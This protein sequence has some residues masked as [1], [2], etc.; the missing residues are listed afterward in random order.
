MSL[1]FTQDW[2]VVRGKEDAYAGFVT[3]TFIPECNKLGL[4]S[5]GGFYVQVGVGPQVISIKSAKSLSSLYEAMGSASFRELKAKLREYVSNYSSK[6]LEPAEIT[7]GKEYEIQKGV[8]KYN[9]YY[10][11]RPGNREAYERYVKETYLPALEEIDYVEVTERWN[12]LI[13]GFSEAIV[14]L[15]FQHP[16][17]IGRLLDNPQFREVTYTMSRDYVRN[18]K[19]RI[20]R[21]TERFDEPRWFRL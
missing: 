18:Y 1:L 6:I 13:G 2:D 17:D 12:V 19:S 9:Q 5:V 16:V 14:E 15:T 21:T 8:W 11:V 7:P 20:L 3:K 10:D 4:Q